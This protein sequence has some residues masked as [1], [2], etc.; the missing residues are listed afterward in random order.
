MTQRS[1]RARLAL[2]AAAAVLAVA[3]E[4]A[5]ARSMAMV[6]ADK[7]QAFFLDRDEIRPPAGGKGTVSVWQMFAKPDAGADYTLARYEFD[8][9]NTSVRVLDATEYTVA[10]RV[11]RRDGETEWST[12]PQNS[13]GRLLMGGAC[14]Q[15]I[16]PVKTFGDVAP[17]EALREYRAWAGGRR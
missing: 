11:V 13:V 17:D 7:E 14:G 12:V 8:C 15:A 6:Q 2:A 9:I 10:G 3:P 1:N 4:V 16:E 5:Q